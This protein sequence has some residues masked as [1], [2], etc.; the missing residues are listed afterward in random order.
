[1]GIGNDLPNKWKTKTNMRIGYTKGYAWG[2]SH[3]EVPLV[4]NP[5]GGATCI[6]CKKPKKNIELQVGGHAYVG[7]ELYVATL[8]KKKKKGKK[9]KAAPNEE[10][11]AMNALSL[12]EAKSVLEN[13]L[14]AEE[15]NVV[16]AWSAAAKIVQENHKQILQ[17]KSR[18][19][20]NEAAIQSLERRISMLK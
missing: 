5:I 13:E 9:K 2:Q 6:T 10:Q 11:E 8:K 3:K 15:L 20:E 4:V 18:I 12:A 16:S 14:G 7:G 17:R 1:M 19:H